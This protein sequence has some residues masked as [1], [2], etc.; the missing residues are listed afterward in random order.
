MI[1]LGD[2]GSIAS[3]VGVA[4]GLPALL[5]AILQLKGLKGE[6]RAAREASEATRKAIGR[7][8]AITELT[9]IGERI[10][11]LKELHRS[12]DRDRCLSAYPEIRDLFLEIRRRHPGLSNQ[13]REDILRAT[14]Q[15]S[16]M[17]TSLEILEVEIT[18]E[19]VGDL[20]AKLNAFQTG[21]LPRVEDRLQ[22]QA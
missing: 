18:P 20:N 4:L 13:E 9:K 21:L 22:E 10:D 1:T 16:E 11:A 19:I 8:L 6:T 3:I 12:G 14:I 5:F 2:V 15:I 7:E 17:E